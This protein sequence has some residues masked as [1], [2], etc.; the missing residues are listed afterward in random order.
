M[1]INLLNNNIY[2]FS[3]SCKLEKRKGKVLKKKWMR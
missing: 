3:S 1:I 2:I